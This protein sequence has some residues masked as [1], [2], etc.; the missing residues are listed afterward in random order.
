MALKVKTAAMSANK[1][2]DNAGRA[3]QAFADGAVEAADAW[4][5]NTANAADNYH[6][7]V[8]AAGIKDRFRAGV[9]KAGA[10]KF[11]R[12]IQDVAK[13]RYA[14]G[15][16]AAQT[17]YQENVTP[18]LTTIAGLTLSARKPKGDPANYKR[19]EE[20]G[21]ALHTKRLAL[22]GVGGSSGT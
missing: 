19:V 4:A 3:S 1:W 2:A 17:D 15:V 8:T 10:D 5:N 22:L 20:V 9:R 7:A 16:A 6:Q 14:P 13:D 21:K 12:K 11:K 18:Y